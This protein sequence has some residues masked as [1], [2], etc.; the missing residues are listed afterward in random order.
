MLQH[1]FCHAGAAKQLW[2]VPAGQ[3]AGLGA[4]QPQ[5]QGDCPLTA[6][7]AAACMAHSCPPIATAQL[8][9]VGLGTMVHAVS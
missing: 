5:A 8:A 1:L 3:K 4:A 9:P 7:S 2:V 6:T